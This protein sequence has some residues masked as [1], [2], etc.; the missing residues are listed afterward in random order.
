M[1]F[2]PKNYPKWYFGWWLF[3]KRQLFFFEQLFPVV[4]RTWWG[5]RSELFF[6]PEILGLLPKNPI[7][8]I[9]PQFC[10]TVVCS[11]RS[12]GSFP[13]LETIFR[14]SVPELQLF[15]FKKIW[16][17]AQKVFPLL[18]VGQCLPVT[19]LAL[20]AHRPFRPAHA[21]D[22]NFLLLLAQCASSTSFFVLY[23]LIILVQNYGDT[24]RDNQYRAQMNDRYSP[25]E[26]FSSND[27][28]WVVC[29]GIQI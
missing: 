21:L 12:D 10:S 7:F 24:Q 28:R 13:I 6:G 27:S 14:L 5:L 23:L 26:Q 11:P 29:R 1:G 22:N 20:S 17:T 3:G 25:V 4:A 16:L 15:P 9:R 8:A 19:A 2:N 18:N